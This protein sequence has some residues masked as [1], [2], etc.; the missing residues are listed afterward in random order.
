MMT[1]RE[2]RLMHWREVLRHR[3][4]AAKCRELSESDPINKQHHLNNAADAASKAAGQLLAVQA[5]ND[6]VSGTA[7]ADRLAEQNIVTDE[8]AEFERAWR[9]RYGV[10]T[11]IF[12]RGEYVQVSMQ[13]GWVMWQE[14]RKPRSN[15]VLTFGGA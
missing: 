9:A 15:D 3:N 11:M 10:K 5:L 1:L 6:V 12:E 8:R 7:E 14:A 4:A 2:L 13:C